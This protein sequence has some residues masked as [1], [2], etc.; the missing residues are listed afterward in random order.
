V[1]A[2]AEKPM[3]P[4]IDPL[5]TC[6]KMIPNKEVGPAENLPV[7]SQPFDGLKD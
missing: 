5:I 1:K 6:E 4:A 3:E 2:G 7:N